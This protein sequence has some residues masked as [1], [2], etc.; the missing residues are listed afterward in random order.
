MVRMTVRR[1]VKVVSKRNDDHRREDAGIAER[2]D[3][4]G[5]EQGCGLVGLRGGQRV[6]LQEAGAHE[7]QGGKRAADRR[8]LEADLQ[9]VLLEFVG[10]EGAFGADE[11]QDLDDMAIARQRAARGEDHRQH[12]GE[13]T[14]SSTPVPIMTVVCAMETRRSTQVR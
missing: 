11:V 2:A 5:A 10:D 7:E 13:K 14:S 1:A 12:H 3:R 6:A 4:E 8:A 9:E